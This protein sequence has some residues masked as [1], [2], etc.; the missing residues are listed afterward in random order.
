MVIFHSYVTNYQRVWILGQLRCTVEFSAELS[1][2]TGTCRLSALGHLGL[3][4][5]TWAAR[6]RHYCQVSLIAS[7]ASGDL[8]TP[9]IIIPNPYSQKL[10]ILI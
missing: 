6:W 10:D 1:T 7:D 2:S 5:D 4:W 9:S 3:P 8:L